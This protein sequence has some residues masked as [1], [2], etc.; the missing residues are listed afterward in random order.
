MGF[1]MH[2]LS[3][4]IAYWF[5]VAF[6]LVTFDENRQCLGIDNNWGLLSFEQSWSNE[7]VH[8]VSMDSYIKK[9]SSEVVGGNSVSFCFMMI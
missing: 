3:I 2:K 6:G 5:V 9:K 7:T 8:S 1:I 4:K